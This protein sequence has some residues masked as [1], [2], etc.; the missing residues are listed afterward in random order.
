MLGRDD[1]Q[2]AA[3]LLEA[4]EPL[5]PAGDDHA[6]AELEGERLRAAVPR[7]V[8]LLAGRPRVAGVLHAQLVARLAPSA[9]A[10]DD[11]AD[12]QLGRRVALRRRDLGLG[13][14]VLGDALHERLDARLGRGLGRRRRRGGLV[15]AAGGRLVVLAAGSDPGGEDEGECQG[16]QLRAHSAERAELPGRDSN[17]NYQSQNLA[18]C[19]LHHPARGGAQ[20]RRAAVIGFP[21]PCGALPFQGAASPAG[22]RGTERTYA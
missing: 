3:A 18:C 13:L 2:P 22:T 10:G 16:E 19:Q 6:G 21:S 5:V 20:Y 12:H 15:A 1:Q 4:D 9:L 7:G 17:P 11:V 8:E 14:R